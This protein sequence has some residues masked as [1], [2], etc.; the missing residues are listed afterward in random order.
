MLAQHALAAGEPDLAVRF[1]IQA[2]R[3]AL[4]ANAPEETLRLVDTAH[5]VASTPGDRVALLRLRDDALHALRRPGQRLEGLA[6]LAA[7]AEALRD[8]SLELDVLLRRAAALRLSQEHDRA[9]D[10]ARRVRNLASER[11][12]P[13]T[14][15]DACIELGQDLL[16]ADLGEGYAQTQS[17]AD[18]DGAAEAFARSA[19][20]ARALGDQ[21]SLAASIRELGIIEVSR[22]RDWFVEAFRAGEHI[23]ILSRLAAGER[24]DDIMPSLPV[25]DIASE[26]RSCF[27]EAL[28]IYESLG[29][30]QGTMATIIAMAF[31]TWG[32]EIHLGGSAKRIEE[33][34]RLSTQLKSLTNESER[35]L[36][37]AQMLFG[38]HVY[39]RAK[40]FPDAAIV[41]GREA[42]AA[43]RGLGDHLLEFAAAGGVAMA[44]ADIGAIDEAE[45]WLAKAAGAASVEPTPYRAR[46]LTSW[47]GVVRGAARDAQGMRDNLQRAVQLAMD[48]GRA[49]ARCEALALLA[50][51]A[52]RLGADRTDE[53]LLSLAEQTAEEA[54]RLAPLLA[55]RHPWV[56]Q[57]DAALAR[58]SRA[59]G[60]DQRALLHG[61][62]VFDFLQGAEREDMY[63]EIVLPAAD[64]VIAAGTQD[65]VAALRGQLRLTLA[66]LTQH[67]ADEDVRARWFTGPIGQE[68]RRLA[69]MET[70][71][72]SPS[73]GWS[74]P[75]NLTTADSNLLRLLAEGGTNRE[76]ADQLGVSTDEISHQL[77]ALFA[78]IGATSRADATSTALMG[79]LI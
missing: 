63:L 49:A 79:R 52:A 72:A 19:E 23:P 62:A 55:G 66:L 20:L 47:R 73:E 65:E 32:P 39:S 37:D 51:E 43:A 16:H 44:Y 68:L 2:A 17:E 70:L 38:A 69:A 15:L 14:E 46:E 8:S 40:V 27:S 6:E 13:R 5:G 61:R 56:A 24:L 28:E 53:E 48:Q 11:G 35:A 41:K 3:A 58:V 29:D 60:D 67:F 26:A 50:R 1:A 77:A 18:I 71:P 31:M 7:L 25:A 76:I 45:E 21:P 9:A 22:L 64:A 4:K 34:R 30:R 42:Y 12:D 33:I 57:A 59:R 78:K 75:A 74:G 36:A 10:L 54:R